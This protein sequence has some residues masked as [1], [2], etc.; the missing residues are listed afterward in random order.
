MSAALKN[1]TL[2]LTGWY[3]II[4]TV[5]SIL[6]SVMVFSFASQGFHRAAGPIPN[7]RNGGVGA[8]SGTW[9]SLQ[10]AREQ[11]IN[12]SR[13]EL[14]VNLLFFN[15]AVLTIGGVC[16]FLLA[17]RTLK[18]IEESIKSQS[19]FSSDAAHELRTPLT[20]MQSEIE[21]NLRNKDA[22]KSDYQKLV[23][24]NLAEVLRMRQLTDRLLQL[25]N[26]NELPV[27]TFNL[28]EAAIEA[29]N[30][31]IPLAIE[32]K[33][34]I[35]NTV[36]QINARGN[37]DATTDALTILLEN[38]IKYS[39]HHK[40]I[41]LSS[42]TKSR[43]VFV[44]VADNGIGISKTDIPH[45]FDRFYQADTS[46]ARSNDANGY[47]LGLPLA[48]LEI[49]SQGGKLTLVSSSKKGSTFQIQLPAA[50]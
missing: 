5:M 16:S 37:A 33:I 32:K 8:N 38:A 30:R 4:L 3:L 19:R 12:E 43:N 9:E 28:E 20:I 7:G 40:S 17:Q 31:V 35:E 13:E 15:I 34:K 45:I 24:S 23:Q 44:S 41:V 11:R 26:Q 42:T 18:P 6:F 39:N 10:K 46:R 29:V 2:R 47:G 48:K 36:S 27:G 50:S 25:A 14:I 21:V 22:T 49:E 1:A